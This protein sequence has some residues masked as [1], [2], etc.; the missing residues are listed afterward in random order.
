[1]EEGKRR[2]TKGVSEED[3]KNHHPH[4]LCLVESD[5]WGPHLPSHLIS[6]TEIDQAQQ[7]SME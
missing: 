2:K 1:M 4:I 7:I 5:W 6:I 3:V